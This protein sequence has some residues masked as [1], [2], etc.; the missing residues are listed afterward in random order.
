M[1]AGGPAGRTPHAPGGPAGRTPDALGGP[2]GRTPDALGGPAGPR[3]GAA[4]GPV[5]LGPDAAD[6]LRAD[7]AP[8][9]VDA[10]EDVLGP[11]AAAALHRERR[12]PALLA[13]DTA[14][15]RNALGGRGSRPAAGDAGRGGADRGSAGGPDS[16][17][18]LTR[19]F[20]LGA[21]ARRAD[22]DAALP[23]LGAAGAEAAGLVAA[24]GRGRDDEVR[25][26]L[27][28][29][30]F[31]GTWLLSDLGQTATGRPLERDHVLGV[32][33]ASLSL[34]EL[35]VRE[36]VGRVLDLGTGCGVQAVLAARHADHVTATDV[37]ARA[38][39][40]ARANLAIAGVDAGLR[41]GSM[42]EP[43]A[44]ETFDLVVSNPPFVITAPA[45]RAGGLFEYR[46][47]GAA[48]DDLVRDLVAGVPAVL[49]PGGVAQFLGNWEHRRGEEWRDRVGSWLDPELDAWV[50]QREV[51][52][53]PAYVET[54]LRDAGLTPQHDRAGYE[55][56]YEAWLADFT[57][58]GVE[59]IG[60]GSV[61][62]RRPARAGARPWRRLEEATG[63]VRSLGAHVAQ[64]L[65]GVDAL[66]ALGP[67]LVGGVAAVRLRVAPDVTEERHHLPGAEDP[68]VV[69][70]RQ[71][72]GY[73]RTRRVG[74][75]EAALVGAS[76]G[77]LTVAQV[78]GALATLLE[79]A[80]DAQAVTERLCALVPELVIE[81][82]VT[83]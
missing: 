38:L 46:D 11:V 14:A 23:R 32:G 5:R 56:A 16:I 40:I 2:A 24:A 45:L 83:L 18:T 30:P 61:T 50:V 31:E 36:P 25:A 27:D 43:V 77:E 15:G 59:A 3:P 37:S 49:A 60:L 54:W 41:A 1:S 4:E 39:A 22:L 70:L 72:G 20:M 53:P 71:G 64:V 62:L 35:T 13:T 47:G 21:T 17:A 12:V 79:G 33:G 78:G 75:E 69:L 81:G 7:L 8:W 9:T 80:G 19:L 63:P 28:L 57:G 68:T 76:D 65:R 58:R 73:G 74:T 52:D 42:L 48:G 34:A 6:A 44:G 55:A 29:R 10:V 51:L 26:L 82:F 66:R 67:D